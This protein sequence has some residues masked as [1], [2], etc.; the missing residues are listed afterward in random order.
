MEKSIDYVGLV[1]QAQLGDKKCLNRLA[2]AVRERLYSYVY[3]YTLADDLANDI[4]QESIL[5]MLEAL[6]ELRKADQFWPWLYKI[7][8]NK[9]RLH[10]RNEQHH[11]TI[12][13]PDTNQSQDHKDSQDAIAGMVYQEFKKTVFAAMRELKPEHRSVINM[14]C[15][16][17]MQYSEIAKVL[18]R[19]EFA[20]QKLFYRAK[21]SLK[22]KLAR[23]GLG[24]GSLLMA[25]VLFG[26][27]TAPSK[28]AAASI[29]I[30]N[31]TVKVGTAV[32]VAAIAASK[33]AI[34][35]LVTA[36]VLAGGT[37]V[38]TSGPDK[39]VA[40]HGQ[41]STRTPYV[42]DQ[43]VQA[44]KGNVECW[45]YY[46]PNGNGAVM[47][48]FKSDTEGERSYFQWLHNN[49]AN[50]YK[51]NNVMYIRSCR[52][53]ADDLSVRR[54]P[55]DSPELADF[56]S[57]VEGKTVPLEYIRYKGGSLLVIAKEEKDTGTS[58][59]IH[60]YDASSEEY[61]R[62]DWL[63]KAKTIDNRDAMHKRG[64]TYFS[65][66]G[67]INGKQ[68]TGTGRI[69]FVY[70][71]SQTHW[72]WLK[73]KAGQRIISEGSFTGLSQPWMGLHTIDTVRRDA[74]KR[75]IWFETELL[76]GGSKAEVTLTH[77]RGKLVYTVDME[78]DVVEKITFLSETG[79]LIGQLEFSYL[80][81]IEN[82]GNEFTSPRKK[83]YAKPRGKQWLFELISD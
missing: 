45:Y 57:Q 28:A 19:S 58:Q 22:K 81:E 23:H 37:M 59:I 64:W 7:A 78:T 26:K 21:K 82:I 32:S 1:Q 75:G 33:T 15:Y 36:G 24:K 46:P 18:G 9:I 11:R 29:S 53:W 60:R 66:A 35:S 12:S 10:H 80:Q 69:P 52:P 40:A 63:G 27:L 43:V 13:D 49:Q 34:V 42:T 5:K 55:T 51:H 76:P 83:G 50:Y 73:L 31:A 2:E 30:T 54:L 14:R 67:Q 74:A 71:T 68:V 47:M 62:Y 39:T 16:D 25:L 17:Q 77:N 48:R 38:A 20:A 65:I 79:K 41:R 44:G 4:V 61:F 6:G 56:L 3:R 8:L 72:P 70:A